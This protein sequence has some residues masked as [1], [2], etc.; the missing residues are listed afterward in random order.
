MSQLVKHAAKYEEPEFN[1]QFFKNQCCLP[2]NT[3]LM[4]AV[5][6]GQC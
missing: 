6:K 3:G 2:R 4:K 5:G 1:A